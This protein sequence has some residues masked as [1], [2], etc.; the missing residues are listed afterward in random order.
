MEKSIENKNIKKSLIE[1]E[2]I[3]DTLIQISISNIINSDDI[4]LN[5][6]PDKFI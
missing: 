2:I 3:F 1:N 5:N 4:I 6:N